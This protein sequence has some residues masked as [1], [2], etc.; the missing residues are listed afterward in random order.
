MTI[1][2]FIEGQLAPERFFNR[3]GYYSINCMAVVDHK[4]RFRH[5]TTRHC[6][7]CHDA[8]IFNE[9]HLRARLSQEFSDV[10]PQVLLGDEGK[11]QLLKIHQIF[12]YRR[13]PM[14]RLGFLILNVFFPV[15][16]LFMCLIKVLVNIKLMLLKIITLFMC[17]NL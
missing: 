12:I 6:G 4:M 16:I 11:Y 9:S 2:L 14:F 5:F 17:L 7:S 1:L 15:F 10:Q 13:K 8:R 3:K